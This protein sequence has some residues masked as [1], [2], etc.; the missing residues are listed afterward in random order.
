ML[1]L[2][3]IKE[4]LEEDEGNE[5]VIVVPT[6]VLQNQWFHQLK[7]KLKRWTIGRMGGGHQDTLEDCHVLV[8]VAA[9]AGNKYYNRNEKE[10]IGLLIADEAHR[11]T[12][13]IWGQAL[14]PE[15]ERRLG[16]TATFEPKDKSEED[17]LLNYFKKV[18]HSYSYKEAIREGVIAKF[19]LAM[20]GVQFSPR[21]RDQYD[22]LSKKINNAVRNLVKKHEA[23]QPFEKPGSFGKFMKHITS[24]QKNGTM[25]EGIAAQRF[26][27][28]FAARRKLLSGSK[29]KLKIL[30]KLAK[31]IKVSNGTILFTESIDSAND[32][33]KILKR[34]HISC[35][36]MHSKM[37]QTER[38]ALLERFRQKKITAVVAPKILD[39]GVD[40]PEVDLGIIIA[41]SKQKRQMIQ[42]MGRVL[43]LKQD[44]RHAKFII[45]YVQGTSEDPQKGAHEAFLEQIEPVANEVENFNEKSS[46]RDIANFL[47]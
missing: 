14:Q 36:S 18:V 26:L 43:R 25:K 17:E 30:K 32:S 11:Y 3:A 24:L 29:A 42:R 23:P 34:K 37:N 39:E 38:A 13:E 47:S 12:G 6:I 20:V 21:E 35:E 27:G 15:F 9:S 46:G 16:L 40:V 2:M 41:A 33:A 22:G 31:A 4:A 8:A 5:I 19:K 1:A 7:E 44:E 45:T 10:Y 28:P